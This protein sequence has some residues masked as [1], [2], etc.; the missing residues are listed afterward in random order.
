MDSRDRRE[1]PVRD[2][3]KVVVEPF[4]DYLWTSPE[5]ADL[6]IRKAV[7]AAIG[8]IVIISI[9]ENLFRERISIHFSALG[10]VDD[11]LSLL[12]II[13]AAIINIGIAYYFIERWGGQASFTQSLSAA[14][15]VVS[16]S[17]PIIV[18]VE[19]IFK[20]MGPMKSS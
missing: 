11:F 2:T 9:V 20:K 1:N 18:L 3:L 12:W 7:K 15:V 19:C 17:L 5:A 14:I 10:V 16:M 6:T 8:S 4:S 13:V